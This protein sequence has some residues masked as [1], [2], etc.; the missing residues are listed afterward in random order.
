MDITLLKE[1][2]GKLLARGK[3][4]LAADESAPT[5]T[6]RFEAVGIL[7]T[8]ESRRTYR[9]IL[10]TTP[11]AEEYISGVILYDET[12]RQ[13][14]SGGEPFPEALVKRGIV[15]GIKVDTGLKDS[16]LCPG[17]KVTEGLNGLE[18]RLA[19][20]RALGARFAK[21]RAAIAIGEHMPTDA[22]IEANADALAKYAALCHE[23]DIVPVIEPEVLID[24]DHSLERCYE[25]VKKTLEAVFAALRKENVALEG[26]ILKTSMVL[27]GKNAPVQA[28]VKEVAEATI[29]CL[30]ES[31]PK[32]LAGIVFLSGGQSDERATAHLDA[33]N[34]VNDT[35]WRLTFSYSRA[36]QN[37]VLPLWAKGDK[38]RAAQ[39]FLFRARMNSLASEG[40]YEEAMEKE[41]PY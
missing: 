32:E 23:A 11:G 25:V 40:K 37:P 38:E 9:E 5:C 34:R 30:K 39:A 6:K 14:T 7:C 41:R 10:L 17:E 20:Y 29:K 28:G 36:L 4:I 19:E 27:S 35:P 33:M 13:K 26:V 24:G 22:C 1:T 3:G 31:V 2:A 18:E 15:P 12:I 8:E 16:P 21:W